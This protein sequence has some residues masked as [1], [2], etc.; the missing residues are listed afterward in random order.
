[1]GNNNLNL[2]TLEPVLL[3]KSSHHSEKPDHHNQE[4]ALFATTRESPHSNEYLAQPKIGISQ[5]TR[6]EFSEEN[7]WA[8]MR[9]SNSG[10]TPS[11]S[12]SGMWESEGYSEPFLPE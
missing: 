9:N 10:R 11:W 5:S 7:S 6:K 3:D 8:N 12:L 2:C 1:M 4:Q